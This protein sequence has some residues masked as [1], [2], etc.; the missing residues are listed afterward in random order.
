[1]I[2]AAIEED[3]LRLSRVSRR[4]ELIGREPELK[5]VELQRVAG[6]LERYLRMRLPRLGPGVELEV[7]VPRD[8][9][10]VQAHEVLLTWALENLVKN[11]L[12]ALAGRGGV[13]SL[14]ARWEGRWVSVRIRDSGPGVDPELRDRI[15]EPGVSSKSGGWGVGLALA[16]RIVEGLHGG[17]IELL[18]GR[19]GGATFQVRLPVA[20]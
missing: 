1:E 14:R 4:F 6:E 3:L 9:P 8:L 16:R 15:F 13:I 18:D 2:A 20:P 5:P 12:D 7:D 17:H 10:R 11:A 19:E